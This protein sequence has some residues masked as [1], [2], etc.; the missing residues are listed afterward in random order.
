MRG[1]RPRIA[2]SPRRRR[3]R[4]SDDS[5]RWAPFG[6]TYS[7]HMD[8][9]PTRSLGHGHI[10][11]SVLC[12]PI[13][14]SVAAPEG[15]GCGDTVGAAYARIWSGKVTQPAPIKDAATIIIVRETADGQA[16]L[17]GQRGAR[18]AFMPGKFVFPGGAIDPN[19]ASTPA[20]VLN[21]VC[22]AALLDQSA[23]AP[24]TI[25]AAAIRELWEETGQILGVA[26]DWPDPPQGWRGFA[27]T[28]QIPNAAAMQFFFR[29][30]TPIGA[31]RRFDARFLLAM[32][33]DLVTDPDDFSGAED[34]LSH[35]QWVPLAH[36]RDFDLPFITQIVLAEL[37]AHLADPTVR[38]SVPFFANEDEKHLVRRLNGRS[39]L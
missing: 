14:I 12:R 21:P 32:A 10:V 28:G 2:P 19:D 22:Q 1:V 7:R 27:A 17:M 35:L 9:V 8:D 37:T 29:A 38:R 6:G 23:L 31:P 39:L 4:I 34:E 30:V 11:H 3:A 26:G 13:A 36:A 18:A 16:V 24:Q 33:D 25:A 5:G 20:G 15:V